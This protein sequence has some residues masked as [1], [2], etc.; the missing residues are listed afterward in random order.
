MKLKEII[1]YLSRY[2]KIT[3]TYRNETEPKFEGIVFELCD[4]STAHDKLL[5]SKIVEIGATLFNLCIVLKKG[6]KK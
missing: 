2:E 4:D 3:L 6:E 1:K 5:N